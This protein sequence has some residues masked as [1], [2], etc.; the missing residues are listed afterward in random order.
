MRCDVGEPKLSK[1]ARTTEA[2]ARLNGVDHDGKSSATALAPVTVDE[3]FAD[4]SA[5][6]DAPQASTA[7]QKETSGRRVDG[8]NRGADHPPTGLS[9]AQP[10]AHDNAEVLRELADR[11]AD[12]QSQQAQIQRLLASVQPS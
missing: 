1:A 11:L 4:E 2:N 8:G 7:H 12:L 6:F 10:T 5:V 3:A 9:G